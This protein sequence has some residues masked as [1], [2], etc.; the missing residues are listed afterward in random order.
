MGGG[1]RPKV[2]IKAVWVQSE[3]RC[4]RIGFRR[5][6]RGKNILPKRDVHGWAWL[7]GFVGFRF[8]E[9]ISK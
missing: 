9:I 6:E 3:K 7:T 8:V 5:Q 4:L 2:E 1:W